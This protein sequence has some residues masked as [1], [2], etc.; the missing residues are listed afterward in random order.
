VVNADS[1]H[2]SQA[3]HDRVHLSETLDR[4]RICQS[5]FGQFS[6][7]GESG[8]TTISERAWPVPGRHGG[9]FELVLDLI[10]DGLRRLSAQA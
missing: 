4:R 6:R 3:R 10:L 8:T 9:S 2:A 5:D 7:I 1:I